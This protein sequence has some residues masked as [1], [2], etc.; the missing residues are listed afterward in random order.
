MKTKQLD[1]VDTLK[2]SPQENAHENER[3]LQ[4]FALF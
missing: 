3:S 4:K 1:V 2:P